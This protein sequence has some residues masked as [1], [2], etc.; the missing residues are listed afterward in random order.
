MKASGLTTLMQS[1]FGFSENDL[2]NSAMFNQFKS[3][4]QSL[5]S[6]VGIGQLRQ[7]IGHEATTI[8][9]ELYSKLQNNQLSAE[10]AKAAISA[11]GKEYE[12]L[13]G[14]MI[15]NENASKSDTK[16]VEANRKAHEALGKALAQNISGQINLKTQTENTTKALEFSSA[17]VKT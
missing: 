11:L 8:F 5:M 9:E 4:L 10:D 1:S 16:T 3:Q 15:N 14:V 17:T 7:T 6:T 2:S 13:T 12:H